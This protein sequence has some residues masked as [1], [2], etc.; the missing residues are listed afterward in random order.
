[1]SVCLSSAP[2][3]V[4]RRLTVGY[5]AVDILA[6]R[7]RSFWRTGAIVGMCA[8]IGAHLAGWAIISFELGPPPAINLIDPRLPAVWMRHVVVLVMLGTVITVTELYVI[9]QLAHEVLVH[10]RLADL[11]LQQRLALERAER[12]RARARGARRAQQALDQARRL[13]RWPA[14]R[15]ASRTTSTTRSPSSSARPTSPN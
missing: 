12:E 4:A 7:R 1:L 3:G 6:T 15:A 5:A 14:C 9:E 10:R 8:V 2:S 11:E 13:E